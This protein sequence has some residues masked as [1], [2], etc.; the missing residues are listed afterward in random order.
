MNMENVK[1]DGWQTLKK[2]TKVVFTW[3]PEKMSRRNMTKNTTKEFINLLSYLYILCIYI[4]MYIYMCICLMYSYILM[5]PM[6]QRVLNKLNKEHNINGHK[7]ST[8][9]RVLKS[10]RSKMSVI[11]MQ[12]WKQCTLP[13]I[14]TWAHDVRLHIADT[15]EP[16]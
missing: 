6:Q 2:T 13:V 11:Y 7:C 10:H 8:T 16:K 9:H 15:N 4:C 3:L 5:V 1:N 12:S 14:T